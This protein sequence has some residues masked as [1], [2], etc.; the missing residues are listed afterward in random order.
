[1][2]PASERPPVIELAPAM[3]N[4]AWSRELVT[5]SLEPLF[6]CLSDEGA[7]YLRPIH[8]ATLRFGWPPEQQPGDV[9]ANA[10]HRYGLTPLLVH[11]TSWRLEAG[12]VILTYVVVVQPPDDLNENLADEHVPRTDLA[13]GD[14]MSAPPEIGIAQVLEHAFRHLSWLVK[15]DDAVRVAL[16]DWVA[17]LGTYVP[18]PFQAFGPP[19]G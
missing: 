15:D 5:Q 2:P 12:H 19:A 14:A 8:A 18:E 1:M 11:S 16:P 7:R 3:A 17:F 6:V 10:A 13:R 4:V 9:V